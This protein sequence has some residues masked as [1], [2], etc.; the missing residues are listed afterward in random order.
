MQEDA[1]GLTLRKRKSFYPPT[2]SGGLATPLRTGRREQKPSPL[3]FTRDARAVRG[4]ASDEFVFVPAAPSDRLSPLERAAGQ[5][6]AALNLK[7]IVA[8]GDL[9]PVSHVDVLNA[10]VNA[11]CYYIPPFGRAAVLGAAALINL[12]DT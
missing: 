5:T 1:G 6:T 3:L 10:V 11:G 2:T 4:A 12:L 8:G 7:T 9:S